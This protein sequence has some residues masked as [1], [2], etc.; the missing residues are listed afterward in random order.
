MVNS[1]ARFLN[2]IGAVSYGGKA[3]YDVI[4][5][6]YIVSVQ[7]SEAGI[8]EPVVEVGAQVDIDRVLTRVLDPYQGYVKEEIVAD[9]NSVMFFRYSDPLSTLTPS[10]SG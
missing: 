1:V 10:P 3:G 8:F 5:E 6:G 7:T 9:Y 4:D 2:S